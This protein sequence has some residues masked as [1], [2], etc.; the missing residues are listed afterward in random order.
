MDRRRTLFVVFLIVLTVAALDIRANGI[1]FLDEWG[2][3]FEMK[4][5]Q[6]GPGDPAAFA[7]A[8]A[9]HT[10]SHGTEGVHTFVVQQGIGKLTIVGADTD[11]VNVELTVHTW[12][13]TDVGAQ[14]YAD[15]FSVSLQHVGDELHAQWRAPEAAE[16]IR[17]AQMT[18]E[19]TVPHDLA[20]DIGS[21]SGYVIVRETSGAVRIHGTQTHVDLWPAAAAPIDITSTGGGV[22]VFLPRDLMNHTVNA[23]MQFG[24]L[25][26]PSDL[27]QADGPLQRVRD[28]SRTA[29]TGTLG[30]GEFPLVLNVTGGMAQVSPV[31]QPE[32]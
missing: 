23:S 4:N 27:L 9:T 7:R 11:V 31:R 3:L 29:V 1:E 16:N 8:R 14:A 2:R 20:L 19:V 13:D 26:I 12:T 21:E 17:L 15:G 28:G 22:R 6:V 5:V 30:A 10:V 32:R 24:T 18:W 25:V